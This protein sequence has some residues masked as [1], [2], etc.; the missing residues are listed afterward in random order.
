MTWGVSDYVY[1]VYV[2]GLLTRSVTLR[3]LR[4]DDIIEMFPDAEIVYK[5]YE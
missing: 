5:K 1:N 2:K 4:S 3:G